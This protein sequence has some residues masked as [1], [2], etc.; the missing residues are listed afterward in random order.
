M[1]KAIHQFMPDTA[2]ALIETALKDWE[3]EKKVER[4]WK[5]DASLWT[6]SDEGQWLGWLDIAVQEQNE[7]P[8]LEKLFQEIKAEGILH[9]VVLGMGGSSLCPAMMAE[10]FEKIIDAPEL[11]VLD[12]TDPLQIKHLEDNIDLKK[13]LFIVSSKSGGTLEPTVF[14][15]YF[16]ARLQTVLGRKEVGDRFIAVT[17]PGTKLETLAKEEKF[18]EV[19]H[20]IPSIGGRYSALSNFGMVPSALMGIS[21][22]D[23]LIYA[24]KMRKASL[25]EILPKDNPGVLL[26]IIMGVCQK[27]NKDKLTF[28]VSPDIKALGAWLEQLL[29]ES[30]GK[31]GKGLIPI[32]LEP[33]TSPDYYGQDRL[34][35]YIRLEEAIDAKQDSAIK[36]L[37]EAG[38]FVVQI[39]VE[40]KKQLGAELFRFEMATA[41]CGSIMKINPFNQPDVEGSKVLAAQLLSTFEK[42][43]KIH[44]P[45]LLCKEEGIE[46]LTDEKNAEEIKKYLHGDLTLENVLR[47]HLSRIKPGDY[48]NLSA[49]IEMS[50]RH[51]DL[52]QHCRV[53]IRDEKKVATC[54]GFGP[55]FLHSTGQAYKGGPNTGVFLQ[56]TAEKASDIEIPGRDYSFG[57]VIDAQAEADFEVLAKRDRRVL[58]VHLGKDVSASLQQLGDLIKKALK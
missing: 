53:L 20:G 39:N 5:G 7:V 15:E 34:F 54:V 52:L 27:L 16:Y 12:S 33:L 4:L 41:V 30:T 36:K 43:R 9:V 46:L 3:K 10:T 29:A 11:H 38:Q 50:D 13:T 32:D 37:I 17:D 14:K 51:F 57:V 28:V 49:F 56:I 6:N 19:F 8:R 22:H 45:N 26:G 21:V 42:T 2:L 44:R 55:R 35:I 1:I 48:V 24:E 23:F 58:R 25:P 18:R 31:E 47:A 40:D